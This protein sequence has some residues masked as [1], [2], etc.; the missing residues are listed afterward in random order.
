MFPV[1]PVNVAEFIPAAT[2][3]DAGIVNAVLVSDRAMTAP[4]AGAAA[5]RVTLHAVLLELP[6]VEGLQ[7][8]PLTMGKG[9]GPVTVLPVAD[10]VRLIPPLETARALVMPIDV[11][12]TPGAKVKLITATV[13]FAIV[14]EFMPETMHVYPPDPAN[15]A[16]VFEAPV[17]TAPAL[18]EKEV[19]SLCEYVNVHCKAAGSLPAGAVKVRFNDIVPSEPTV[20]DDKPILSVCPIRGDAA[21]NRSMLMKVFCPRNGCRTMCFFLDLVVLGLG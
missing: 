19:T 12:L 21:A 11:V 20:P 18:T 15:H 6:N 2:V 3:T 10:K 9:G 17:A 14:L 4:P 5:L 7:A 16:N 1:V 13:P 8:N